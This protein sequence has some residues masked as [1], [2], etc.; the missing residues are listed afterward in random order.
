MKNGPCTAPGIQ[1]SAKRSFT[2]SARP[3][4]VAAAVNRNAS[5]RLRKTRPGRILLPTMLPSPCSSGLAAVIRGMGPC[6][7]AP[8]QLEPRLLENAANA[9]ALLV[10]DGEPLG[11][12]ATRGLG[13]VDADL[14]DGMIDRVRS[15]IEDR[16]HGSGDENDVLLRTGARDHHPHDVREIEDVDRKSAR[17]N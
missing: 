11:E 3:T 16:T 7:A 9:R 5:P 8:L 2:S 10:R 15:R 13:R 12:V 4:P 6:L 14:G 17:L 1:S